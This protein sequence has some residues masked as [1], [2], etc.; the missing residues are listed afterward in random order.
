MAQ[1]E[2]AP[3]D[4]VAV[5][6]GSGEALWWFGSLVE[7]KTTSQ[8]SGGAI[9]VVEITEPPGAVAPLHVHHREDEGFWM[10]DGGA[11]FEVG[12]T[13]FEAGPGDWL[14]GPR[15]VPHRYEVG[16]DGCRMLFVLTPGGFE[17]AIR[18]MSLPATARTL[19][20]PSTPAPDLEGLGAEI[21]AYGCEILE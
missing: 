13:T 16:E 17:E 7:I 9:A 6:G 4:P 2:Q 20:P 15:G 19:P 18:M 11:T 21:A 14:L 10:I 5:A 3:V 12:E 1:A 8:Q